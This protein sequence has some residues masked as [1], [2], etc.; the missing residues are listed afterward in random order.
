MLA[1]RVGCYKSVV[2]HPVPQNS[3]VTG[4]ACR[5]WRTMGTALALVL[6]S[7]T[8]LT[9]CISKSKARANSQ[10]AF[11][12]GQSQAMIAAEAKQ[13]GISF[14]GQVLVPIVPWSEGL[15]LAQAII[16]ARWTGLHDPRLVIVT[17]AG[18]RVELTPNESLAA[19]EFPLAAGDE[20][21][22]VP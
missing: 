10:A 1:P 5:S 11:R 4:R 12:A 2:A 6:L 20:V 17:R 14:T 19:A 8:F 13:H 9:G 3:M 15:T 22:L 16:A 7:A 18:E 21:E